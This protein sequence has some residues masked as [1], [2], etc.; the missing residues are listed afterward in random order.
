M[1]TDATRTSAGLQAN[2]GAA[3]VR[4]AQ[5]CHLIAAGQHAGWS[6]DAYTAKPATVKVFHTDSTARRPRELSP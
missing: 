6:I 1:L 4:S 3:R 5:V 2:A